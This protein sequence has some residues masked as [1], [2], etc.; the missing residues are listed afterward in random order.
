[1]KKRSPFQ[2]W[3]GK[4]VNFCSGCSN[5]CLYCYVR[6]MGCKFNWTSLEGWTTMNV[7]QK[8]VNKKHQ[9]YKCQV[10]VP[11]SHDITPEIL[12][13]TINVLQNLIDAGNKR[14]LIVS[15]PHLECI[16]RICD[17]FSDHKDK[18]V[19]RFTIGSV[20]DQILSYWEP[21]APQFLERITC[22]AHAY[23]KGFTTSVS[24]EPIL[25]YKNIDHLIK[26]VSKHVN[27]TIWLGLM[28][29]KLYFLKNNMG[30]KFNDSITKI[31]E[32]QTSEKLSAL[33]EK[34][35]ANPTI[36]FTAFFRKKLTL[37]PLPPEYLLT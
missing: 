3:R 11:S 15:K 36:R 23:K 1:M 32:N 4:A 20:D 24:I 19:F 18:I 37:E 12:E 8:D 35:K 6:D 30:E 34:F 28:N 13:P 17:E 2:D 5:N 22:L 14:I 31:Y 25:D 16:T 9:D 33:Y 21:G 10:M 27:Q 7:R 29:P 26:S